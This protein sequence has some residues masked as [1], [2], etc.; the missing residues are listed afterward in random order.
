MRV[1]ISRYTFDF[2]K[3][4][5]QKIENP[6]PREEKVPRFFPNP[7]KNWG[8]KRKASSSSSPSS[9]KYFFFRS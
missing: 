2:D 6:A 3:I 9:S 7:E 1:L 5:T 8:P 4:Q